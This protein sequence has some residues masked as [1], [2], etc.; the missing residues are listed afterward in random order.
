VLGFYKYAL[1]PVLLAQ[2][3]RVRR[4]ALRLPEPAGDRYGAVLAP[5][6]APPVRLLFVGDS[7]AV[8]VGVAHQDHALAS[9]CAVLLSR[10]TGRSVEWRLVAKSGV[11]TAQALAMLG[12][13]DIRP[14]E[15]AIT[16]LGV[17]DVTSQTASQRFLGDYQLL[18]DALRAR[19]GVRFGVISGLPPMH[20]FSL[21]PYPLRWYLGEY[22]KRLDAQLRAWVASQPH[23]RYVSLGWTGAQQDLAA[24]GYHPGPGQ[25]RHW[26]RLV[27]GNIAELL[28]APADQAHGPSR[29]PD[30]ARSGG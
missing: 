20:E 28:Q 23:L 10:R 30:P 5:G 22:A 9:Q 6:H 3:A 15:I 1:G 12:T 29:V 25:Y 13:H 18:F 8:G 16:A 21:I 17:N 26:A 7:S 27:A 24:D 14:A 11:D 4:S 2:A 19:A